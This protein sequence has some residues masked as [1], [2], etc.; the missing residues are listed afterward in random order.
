MRNE[1]IKL[2]P[3]TDK[4]VQIQQISTEQYEAL[5]QSINEVDTKIL[6]AT[7]KQKRVQDH[8]GRN[9]QLTVQKKEWKKPQRQTLWKYHYQ[10]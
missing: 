2:R 4:V 6:I 8:P 3:V 5:K 7:V 10:Y 9:R 1:I